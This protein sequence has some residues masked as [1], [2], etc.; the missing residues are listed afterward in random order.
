MAG[1]IICSIVLVISI[2]MIVV[3]LS[4]NRQTSTSSSFVKPT[5]VVIG[6]RYDFFLKQY[7]NE[8]K[9]LLDEV[10]NEIWQAQTILGS[11]SDQIKR[12][13]LQSF[14]DHHKSNCVSKLLNYSKFNEDN[15]DDN[16]DPLFSRIAER[17]VLLQKYDPFDFD[18]D[19][20]SKR[21]EHIGKQLIECGVLSSCYPGR[22]MDYKVCVSNQSELKQILSVAN[23]RTLL[24]KED[25]VKLNEFFHKREIELIGEQTIFGTIPMETKIKD[26]FLDVI[27]AYEALSSCASKW[28]IL[29]ERSNTET[30]SFAKTISDRKNVFFLCKKTF[31]YLNPVNLNGVPFFN[32]ENAG[33]DFYFYPDYIIAARSATNFDVIPI[34]DTTILFNKINF[35]ETSSVLIP[36][37]ARIVQYTYKYINKDGERDA[38]YVDNPRYSVCEYGDITFSTYHL[39]MEFSNSEAAENFSKKF[40]ILKNDGDEY[41]DP[42]FGITQNFFDEAKAIVSPL[43][44]FYES[45][46][47]NKIILT[48]IDHILPDSVGEV[49]IK[50]DCLFLADLV[51]GFEQLGHDSSDIL[52]K[53]GLPMAI[54]ESKIVGNIQIDYESLQN[55]KVINKISSC[56]SDFNKSG[57][58]DLITGRAVD[59]FYMKEVFKT[60]N[61][62][63]LIIQYFS[64]LYRF[65]SIVAKADDNITTVESQ[66]LEKLMSYA[67]MDKSKTNLDNDKD[68]KTIL[69]EKIDLFDD[70]SNPLEELQT[71]I[72]LSEVKDEV[73]ALADFVKIQKERENKGMKSV[74]LSYHCVFTGNPGT[75]KTSVARIL[76]A[77]YKNLGILKKGHLVE[78]DR[79]GLVAEYVG[80][81]AIKTNNIIDSALD[82][83][84]FI[85]EAYS[86]VQ[87]GS[88]DFGQEAISTL[89]KRMEDDRDRLVVVLAGYSEDMKHFIDSNP[90]LQSRFS[91]YIHFADYTSQE[92]A[93]IFLLNVEKNQYQLSAD[94]QQML[95]QILSFAVEH[96]DKNFGNGR[97]VRNMFEK[98]I[99][100]QATRL[101]KQSKITAEELS[102]LKA[103]DLPM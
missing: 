101:A 45:L 62:H 79:S 60:I 22:I 61:R 33:L 91:R 1:I 14:I 54:I 9:K 55:F 82:G 67:N 23:G 42:I 41:I 103:E 88:N 77:I 95:K 56:L 63:D 46:K 27:Q 11:T 71:L 90:G 50:L 68:S 51:K 4:E 44:N 87:S 24:L 83:V 64:L 78:T 72:G 99:Q 102:T 89:L 59:F 86:L 52:S 48:V 100:N 40:Q 92:L 3:K 98:T 25:K 58:N 93:E 2:V 76:A 43:Y 38:R 85:D 65:F 94:G 10:E 53:E 73:V 37:D 18:F 34:K 31:N 32:F 66:W 70:D 6:N 80:Q 36:K 47:Q 69:E 75:G 26:A 16:L 20:D 81:T 39:T 74:G 12:M 13:F 29:S 35:V 97:F 15:M 96:K 57:L 7:Q 19:I 8:E 17:V 5:P 21:M 49:K 30:K 28:E 84:L